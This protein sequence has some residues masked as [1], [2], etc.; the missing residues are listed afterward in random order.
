MDIFTTA[1]TRVVPVPIKPEEL[2]VK[3]LLKEAKT[4]EFEQEMDH[5]EHAG[6]FF[7]SGYQPEQNAD[8]G[9]QKNSSSAG[10]I[11]PAEDADAGSK[12]SADKPEDEPPHL[13]IFV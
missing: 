3:A 9:Q 8:S 5:L 6:S 10:G 12:K 11:K 13:D 1:L 7:I 2:K 4:R